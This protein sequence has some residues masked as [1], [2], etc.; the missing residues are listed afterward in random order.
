M[1]FWTLLYALAVVGFV[2]LTDRLLR[3]MAASFHAASLG[4]AF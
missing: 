1:I 4:N 2:D 3:Y